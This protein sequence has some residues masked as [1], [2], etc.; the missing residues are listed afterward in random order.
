MDLK[1][2]E[3]QGMLKRSM[4]DFATKEIAPIAGEIDKSGEFPRACV[5]KLAELGV[6][7]ILLPP[8]YGGTGPDKLG[9]FVATEQI[10]VASASVAVSLLHSNAVSALILALGNDEQK[11]KFLPAL[12]KGQRLGALCINESGSGA[13]WSVTLQTTARADGESYVING[14]KSFISNGGEAEIYLVLARTDPA[15][16]PMGISGFIV[17]KGTPGFSFGKKEEK[18]GLR[19]D[20]TRELIFE[21]CRV[22]RANLLAEGITMPLGQVMLTIG[23]PAVGAAAVGVA[24]AALGAAIDYVKQ[25]AVTPGQTLA[26]FDGIQDTIA[27]MSTMVEASRLLVYQAGSANEREA[28]PTLGS[29]A[30]I[31]PCEAALAVTNKASQVLGALGYTTGFPVERYLR[32]ARGLMLVGQPMEMRKLVTGRLKLG[33]PPMGPPGGAPPRSGAA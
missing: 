19:G 23:L 26:N 13:N 32:D 21:D 14:T 24:S 12:A 11:T 17:D 1:L 4:K 3:Q 29:M 28:D 2:T 27:D 15:K 25:R 16:G 9:F 5:S 7:G 20:V 8:A 22:P 18:L 31:F 6:F 33:L 30:S 10:S